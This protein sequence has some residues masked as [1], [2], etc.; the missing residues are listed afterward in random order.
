MVIVAPQNV[1][2]TCKLL[3]QGAVVQPHSSEFIFHYM[4][5][6]GSIYEYSY[7]ISQFR[8][9]QCGKRGTRMGA[10]FYR[11][12]TNLECA[13]RTDTREYTGFSL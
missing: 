5:K 6:V 12:D 11:L 8:F 9:L 7:S 3:G 1:G 4:I 2:I 10:P 13:A